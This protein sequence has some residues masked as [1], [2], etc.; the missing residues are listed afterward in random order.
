MC[1]CWYCLCSR[2]TYLTYFLVTSSCSDASSVHATGTAS[3]VGDNDPYIDA[4]TEDY[5]GILDKPST[6]SETCQ[7]FS[8]IV[9]D[10]APVVDESVGVRPPSATIN[11]YGAQNLMQICFPTLFPDG[12]GGYRPLE[13]RETHL[14]Q[15]ELA[16]FCAHLMS[17]HDRRFVIHKTFKFFCLNLIQRRQ[18]DGLVRRVPAKL[19]AGSL[20]PTVASSVAGNTSKSTGDSHG[21]VGGRGL[22]NITTTQTVLQ[23]RSQIRVVLGGRAR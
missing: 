7:V 10:E 18:I 23:E 2:A 21:G 11:E 14:Y 4:E 17:W 13:D 8:N 16:E 22:R 19:V 3:P 20:N 9:G 12:C 15:Y 1:Y 5:F 6:A